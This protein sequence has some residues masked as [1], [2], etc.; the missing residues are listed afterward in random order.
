[1]ATIA[2]LGNLVAFL[3]LDDKAFT[4]NL[5]G[6]D[7]ATRVAAGRMAKDVQQ[8]RQQFEQATRAVQAYVAYLAVDRLKQ[9]GRAA[10]DSAGAIQ[11]VADKVG[12]TTRELQQMRFAANQTGVA[13]GALDVAMQRVSRRL[14]EAQREGK[15]FAGVLSAQQ[16][17]GKGTIQ[18]VKLLADAIQRAGSDQERLRIA[19]KAFDTEGA[20]LVNTLRDG[21]VGLQAYMDQAVAFGAVMDGRVIARAKL[22]GD[23]L[24]ALETIYM[25]A[26]NTAIVEGFA[27]S[28]TLTEENLRS[29]RDTGERFGQAIGVALKVIVEAAKLA[30]ENIR[31]IAAAIAAFAA[32]KAAAIFLAAGDA[33]FV[34]TR[35]L[36]AA[37][38][39]GVLVNTIMSRSVL[40]VI[41][42]LA[43]TLGAGALAWDAFGKDAL[44]A[45]F[46]I[47]DSLD[48]INTG[49]VTDLTDQFEALRDQLDPT[50]KAVREFA[51]ADAILGAQAKGPNGALQIT[52]ELIR[53][54]ELLKAK[55][56]DL[57]DPIGAVNRALE[58]EIEL[59]GLSADERER[60]TRVMEIEQRLLQQGKILRDDERQAIE[61]QV[62]ALQQARQARE[63]F[64]A[65]VRELGSFAENAFNKIGEAVTQAFATGEIKAIEFGNIA[66][67]ILSELI[68]LAIRLAVINPIANWATGTN[69]RPSL[70]SLAGGGASGGGGFSLP[71]VP[72]VPSFLSGPI[73]SFGASLGFGGGFATT[74][75]AA[76]LGVAAVPGGLTNVGISSAP[77]TSATLSG[78]LGAAG[79]G[80]AGG[81]LIAQ[82]TGG[83]P[84]TGGIGGA[85]GAGIG[86]AVGGPIGGLIGGALGGFGGG[87]IGG[88][89]SV[90]PNSAARLAIVDGRYVV[91]ARG[92]DN[93]GDVGAAVAQVQAVAD[94]L[95]GLLARLGQRATTLGDISA[96]VRIGENID[97]PRSGDDLLRD[98]LRSGAIATDGLDRLTKAAIDGAEAIDEINQR[99]DFADLVNSTLDLSRK[100]LDAARTL[101]LIET[102]AARINA[103]FDAL[104]TQAGALGFGAAEVET[105]RQNSLATLRINLDREIADAILGLTDPNA[106]AVEQLRRAQQ[107]RV[108]EA[109]AAGVDLVNVER[110]NGLERA[111]LA[112]ELG[113]QANDNFKQA[114]DALRYGAASTLSLQEQLMAASSEFRALVASGA[115]DDS[116]ITAGNRL[117]ELRGQASGASRA[118]AADYNL[119]LSTYARLAGIPGYAVGTSG[120]AAGLAIVGEAGPELVDFRGGERVYTAART[121]EI[122]SDGANG[123]GGGG[124]IAAAIVRVGEMIV[125]ALAQSTRAQLKALAEVRAEIARLRGDRT[126]DAQGERL[127]K[128]T[129]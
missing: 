75:T 62:A 70:F 67:A 78:T 55:Y 69:S 112:A 124:S 63:Q 98:V 31:L 40:G 121:S 111:R 5:Q 90:G 10:L 1:M 83:N 49:A 107:Q 66:R 64:D 68:Q 84:V 15:G 35:T 73:D 50:A 58:R 13:S 79:L 113:Q 27:D 42:K 110:L 87:L 29:A 122:L 92:A 74:P 44:A 77:F 109:V 116:V 23:A 36:L 88:G 30:A 61:R 43:V 103:E 59:A 125:A 19:F 57:V 115:T 46:A 51:K 56:R 105:A 93:G 6:A 17:A 71:N 54:Y 128:R 20:A 117:I 22:A 97:N 102:S 126:L 96:A 32:Y 108:E 7:R 38:K 4:R 119:V 76:S 82:L 45:I 18:V 21:A 99:L 37:S 85:L 25:T 106:L 80:F 16:I 9:F 33:V 95:N 81:S 100:Q 65:T 101:G 72:S 26:F 2:N 94:S 11:D 14:G 123:L 12:L 28:I 91:G 53:L 60:V 52:P 34:F 8:V 89:E 114:F 129:G 24:S 86:F 3:T 104:A 41:A 48:G 39:A 120:A 118:Y 127:R 47:E